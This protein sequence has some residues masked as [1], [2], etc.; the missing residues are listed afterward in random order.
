MKRIQ[1]LA[2]SYLQ[3]YYLDICKVFAGTNP[4][5]E[6]KADPIKSGPRLPI[7]AGPRESIETDP[8]E[9]INTS[10]RETIKE[11]QSQDTL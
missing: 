3:N 4:R 7:E 5:V 11:Y 8:R 6:I 10:Y 9:Q 2:I 1:S